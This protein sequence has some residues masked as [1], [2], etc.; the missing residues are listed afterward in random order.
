MVITIGAPAAPMLVRVLRDP[1][2]PYV[3]AACLLAAV[4]DAERRKQGAQALLVRAEIGPAPAALWNAI[5]WLNGAGWLGPNG[6]ERRGPCNRKFAI[7]ESECSEVSLP[8]T[9]RS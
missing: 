9:P 7:G 4:G 5:G 8:P 2:A 6:T 1:D 3:V